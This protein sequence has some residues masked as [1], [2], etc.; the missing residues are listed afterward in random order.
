MFNKGDRVRVINLDEVPE[1]FE[2]YAECIGQ[3]GTVISIYPAC[4]IP[5]EVEFDDSD[6]EPTYFAGS[7]LEAI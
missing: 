5:Y 6:I 2:H 4:G 7:E 3:T 1:Y